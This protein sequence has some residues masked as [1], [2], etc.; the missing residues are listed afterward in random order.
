MDIYKK[1]D[2]H[3]IKIGHHD[4]PQASYR[5]KTDIYARADSK[6]KREALEKAYIDLIPEKSKNRDWERNQG[7]LDWLKGLHNDMLS[8]KKIMESFA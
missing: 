3:K 8:I 7:L 6:Q 5:P 2:F 1:L 4:F